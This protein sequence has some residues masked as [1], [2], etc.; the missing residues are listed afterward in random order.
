MF[1]QILILNFKSFDVV[2]H[3]NLALL[4]GEIHVM[5]SGNM[6]HSHCRSI[7]RHTPTENTETWQKKSHT[8][9]PCFHSSFHSVYLLGK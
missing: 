8:T 2:I 6:T 5:Y 7:E 1:T 3:T 4:A 9:F